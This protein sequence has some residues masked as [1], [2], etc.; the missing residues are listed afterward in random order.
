MMV[1]VTHIEIGG[2]IASAVY[3]L[4]AFLSTWL[5]IIYYQAYKKYKA[6]VHIKSIAMLE[7]VI[8]FDAVWSFLWVYFI[9]TGQI[10]ADARSMIVPNFVMFLVQINFLITTIQKRK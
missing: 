6:H 5:A 4:V 1:D 3:M 9:I 8:A 2:Y 10:D 7:A